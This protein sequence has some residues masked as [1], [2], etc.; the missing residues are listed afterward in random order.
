M[1]PLSFVARYTVHIME[2]KLKTER[3]I[4]MFKIK[5]DEVGVSNRKLRDTSDWMVIGGLMVAAIGNL[6]RIVAC[7]DFAPISALKDVKL[8]K[9]SGGD[10][11]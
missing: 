11:N 5:I 1:D 7:S 2:K 8:D 9:D 4:I 10:S 3:R 6:V